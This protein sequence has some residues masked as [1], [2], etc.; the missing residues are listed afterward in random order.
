MEELYC[1]FCNKICINLNSLRNHE[2]LCPKNPNRNHKWVKGR[3][4]WS[5][6]KT[7]ENDPRIRMQV[8]TYKSRMK[9]GS[10]KPSHL[11]KHLSKEHREALSEALKKAHAEGRAHNI[12]ESR[13]K[14]EHSFPEKWLIRVLKNEFGLEEN[15]D[16]R[17]ELPFHRFS[18]DFA[19]PERKICIEVDGEQHNTDHCQIIRD[20]EKDRLLLEENWSELRIPWKEC[21]SDPKKWIQKVRELLF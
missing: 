10:I 15:R 16:Y 21:Y 4:G 3:T 5:K 20:L 17:T 9:D 7:A 11:G 14:N 13:W 18:L 8:E 6:G 19:W 2:R 1:K 12:G